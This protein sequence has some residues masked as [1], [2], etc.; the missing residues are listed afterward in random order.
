MRSPHA[1]VDDGRLHRQ[2]GGLRPPPCRKA[3]VL[4]PTDDQ[5][6]EDADVEKAKSLLQT[7][8]DLAVSFAWLRVSARVVVEKDDGSSVQIQGALGDHPRV[9]LAAVDGAEEEMLGR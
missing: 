1:R 6:V 2:G 3:G 7:L 5:V 4:T 8:G 9:H